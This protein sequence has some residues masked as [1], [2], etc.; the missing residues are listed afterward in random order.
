MRVRP[1][2]RLADVPMTPV[3]CGACGAQVL[4]RKSSWEQTSVQWTADSLARCARRGAGPSPVGGRMPEPDDALAL[5]PQ[6]R[7]AIEASVHRGTLPVLD[8]TEW[9]SNGEE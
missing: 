3:D 9:S 2:N 6:L 5:C 4:V 1:D 8:E 7:E